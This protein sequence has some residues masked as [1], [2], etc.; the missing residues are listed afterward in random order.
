MIELVVRKMCLIEG[1]NTK[2]PE[3]GTVTPI[4]WKFPEKED[5]VAPNSNANYEPLKHHKS[6]RSMFEAGGSRV[7]KL[8]QDCEYQLA[9]EPGE[10]QEC[11]PTL[12]H[13]INTRRRLTT[14]DIALY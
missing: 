8:L 4:G 11:C 12:I 6:T 1:V 7:I 14:V 13:L 10:C 9:V 2:G 3:E 5:L